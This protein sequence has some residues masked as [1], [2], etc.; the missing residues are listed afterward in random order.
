[1]LKEW[2]HP[3]ISLA[4]MLFILVPTV[5]VPIPDL[6]DSLALHSIIGAWHR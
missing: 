6:P 2:N 3:V 5:Y 4:I 1:M